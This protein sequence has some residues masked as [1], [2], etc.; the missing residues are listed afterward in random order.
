MQQ[1][2]KIPR[3]SC[4]S[5]PRF[6]H[7]VNLIHRE[8]PFHQ[9]CILQRTR[10]FALFK[11]L[12]HYRF[13]LLQPRQIPRYVRIYVRHILPLPLYQSIVYVVPYLHIRYGIAVLLTQLLRYLTI[14]LAL[15]QFCHRIPSV[16]LYVQLIALR[17]YRHFKHTPARFLR[18][19][20]RLMFVFCHNSSFFANVPLF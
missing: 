5:T 7:L 9:G 13:Y 4:H 14:G 10:Q 15:R 8:T 19:S 3:V 17:T 20:L 18:H 6:V 1:G 12:Q 2:F 11:V 16:L